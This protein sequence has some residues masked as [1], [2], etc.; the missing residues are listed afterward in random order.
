MFWRGVLGYLPVNLVQALAGF[1]AIIAFTRLLN[2]GQY[3]DYALGFAASSLVQTLLFTWI[4]AAMAR[5]YM[6][7]TEGADRPALFAT[8]Y[9]TFAVMALVLPLAAAAALWLLPLSQGLR[10]AILAGLCAT[11]VRSLLKMAQERRRASGKVA[12][13][14]LIDMGQ[15]AGA[16]ALG[17]LAAK[18][19]LGG[20]AP[21]IGSAAASGV[22]CLIALPPE[23]VLAS[24]GRFDFA[25]LRRYAAYGWPVA[26]SL[27]MSLAIAN[28]DRFVIAGFMGESAVGAYHAGY[29]LANRTL[30]VMF[31]WLGMAG[32][33]AAVAALERGGKPELF[34]VARA[35]V[36]FMLLIALPAC[37]GLALVA[38]PLSHLMVGERL[39]AEAAEVTTW[40]AF[41]AAFSGLNTHYFNTA[42]TLAR[43]TRRLFAAIALPAAANLVLTLVLVPRFGLKGAMFAALIS[44]AFGTLT[45]ILLARGV[46]AL[47]FPLIGFAKVLAA[48]AGM[49]AA[50]MAMP[51]TG[52]LSELALKAGVGVTTYAILAFALD[53]GEVRT[54]ARRALRL[55]SGEAA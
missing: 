9:R 1:G 5:F 26:L 53:A 16:F 47:P 29:S 36:S 50:V 44:Y 14:A 42:F 33:P 43:R 10:A 27:I 52:G 4:E 37:A 21:L 55:K 3:G 17:L 48:A 24:R 40:I 38:R 20:A 41:S 6:A 46:M 8:L 32:W 51:A 39:A 28:T 30:D 11:I 49:S 2:P 25:R 19:G 18:M 54:L 31:I 35:Q 34:R 12:S 15:T 13:Y 45:S 23:L 7:E 22:L